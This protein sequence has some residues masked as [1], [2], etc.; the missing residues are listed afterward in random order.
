MQAN[1][2]DGL[3][4]RSFLKCFGA[5]AVGAAGAG[6]LG[7][8]SPS[9]Q[10]ERGGFG[11]QLSGGAAGGGVPSFMQAPEAIGENEIKETLDTEV[12]IVGGGIAG[13]ATASS[14]VEQG[15]AVVVVEKLE[16][17]RAIGLDYGL[18]NPSIIAEKGLEPADMYELTRDHIEKSCGACRVDK[19]Y[20]FMSKSGEAGDWWI[21]KAKSYGFE[22]QVMA[23]RSMSD[24]YKN[25]YIVELWHEGVNLGEEEDCYAPMAE[26]LAH[27]KDEVE[28]SGGEYR[29]KTKAVQLIKSDDGSIT[30]AVCEGPD[31][32]V[33]IN[34]S[35][36]VVLAA[37]DYAMDEEML[38]YYTCLDYDSFDEDSF[39]MEST[40]EGDG[41]KMG[42]WAGAR[43]QDAPHPQMLFLGYAYGYLRVNKN[44]ERYVNE[45]SGYT[46][47]VN[48]QLQ[49]PGASSYAIWDA[50]WPEELPESLKYGGGMSWDQDFRRI[51][52]EW[53]PEREEAN[54]FSW[55]A[56]DG[57]LVQA[58]TLDELAD[59]M[60]LGD[61]A[62]STF[63][64]T[65]ERYNECAVSG[66]I[67]FG[68]RPELMYPIEKAPFYA[69]KMCVESAVSVGGLVTN[70]DSE[71]L[72]DD[73]KVIKGLYAVGNNAGGLFAVDYNEV[74]IPGISIGRSVT[75]GY[76][77]GK[78]L[79]D[80]E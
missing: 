35:K 47:G 54:A 17:P 60:G 78:H 14:C 29:V 72:D 68:K 33:Q 34:A 80:V 21:D 56:E 24:H 49:Q 1:G 32:Y 61:E 31:G 66:D 69:L 55:E 3:S 46:G 2:I 19:V 28:A 53:T 4:R 25:N 9:T 50:K 62:K 36:G 71:C 45:D 7:G 42:L 22:P 43:M 20:R 67:D 75:F 48:A 79:A 70:A 44:G 16:T 52:D 63:L 57:L 77:L 18:V 12:L 58:D 27:V 26:M 73:G 76:L 10:G 64:K 74:T 59:A 5:G 39:V 13:S 11:E 41:H 65:V 23:M 37:G 38:R 8:C 51:E 40:G 30:G 15:L 6:F